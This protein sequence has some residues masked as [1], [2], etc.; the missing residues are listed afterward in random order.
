[1]TR[2]CFG[3]QAAPLCP[4]RGAAQTGPGRAF[5]IPD[6]LRP[7][8]LGDAGGCDDH[9]F[10]VGLVGHIIHDLGHDLLQHRPESAGPDAA[11]VAFSAAASSA[12]G[13]KSNSTLS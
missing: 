9:F 13:W 11:L 4:E 5:R 6:Q 2:C 8:L 1:M 10:D 12:S 3:V 7:Y